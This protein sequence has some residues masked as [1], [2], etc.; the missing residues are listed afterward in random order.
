MRGKVT[1]NPK[2]L[3]ETETLRLPVEIGEPELSVVMPAYNVEGVIEEAVERTDRIVRRTGLKYE[4]IVVD[5]GSSDETRR[6]AKN[7]AGKN[8]HVKVVG[9]AKNM[10]KGHAVKTGFTHA[11]GDSVVFMDGDMD[12]DP[13]QIVR[14]VKA[15]EHGDVVIA[16]KWHPKSRVEMPLVR[17]ILSRG[18]NLLVKLLTGMRLSDTQTGL[19]AVR[20]KAVEKIFPKLS[21]KRYAFDVEMLTLA[22]LYGLKIVELP[23]KIQTRSLFSIKEIWRMFID[24]LGIA[25]RL[26]IL[27]YYESLSASLNKE[28]S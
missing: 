6:K 4:L 13:E 16:S 26:R 2:L 19:K 7:Y 15:L 24:L 3:L 21:V 23:V 20:R 5:D 18:F 12:I 9:Y 25:Y 14:Y 10:G 22:N 17:K 11:K 28:L 27:K 8:E 1:D